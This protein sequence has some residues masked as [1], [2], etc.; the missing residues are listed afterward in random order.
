MTWVKICGIRDIK[1]AKAAEAA[2]SDAI[3][4]MFAESTRKIAPVQAKDI[5]QS[6]GK[7]ILKIGVFVNEQP[8]KINEIVRDCQLDMVQ[9]HGEEPPNHLQEIIVPVIKAFRVADQADLLALASYTPYAFLLDSK[10]AGTQG[11]SGQSFDWRLLAELQ[12]K[13]K[14]IVA[15][16]LTV[17]NVCLAIS[18]TAAFGVDVSSGVESNGQKDAL[19]MRLFVQRAKLAIDS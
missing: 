19:K 10:V 16:G 13:R 4:F 12:E 14:I 6:L 8:A 17:D 5:I 2:G 9:L 11:G 7:T 15:G 1:S 3:G 18:T